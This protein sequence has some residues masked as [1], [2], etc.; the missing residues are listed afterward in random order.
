MKKENDQAANYL[1]FAV[2]IP[3]PV[4][5]KSWHYLL[6]DLRPSHNAFFYNF[7]VIK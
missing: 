2:H 5:I 3:T 1:T 6:L 4:P 7:L